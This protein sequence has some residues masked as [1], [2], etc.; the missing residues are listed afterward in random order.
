MRPARQILEDWGRL[1]ATLAVAVVLLMGP[2]TAV[3]SPSEAFVAATGPQGPG[4]YADAIEQARVVVLQEMAKQRIPGMSAA[5]AVNGEII[6]SE[7]FGYA[8]LENRVPAWPTTLYR[9]GSVSKPLT[10]A[11]VARLYEQGHLELDAPVQRYVPS[12]PDKRYA[13]STRQV[14][15]HLAGIRAYREDEFIAAGQRHYDDVVDALVIF[16][17]DP[18]LFPPGKQYSY[19]SFGWNLISAV[20]RGAADK[21]FLTVMQEEVFDPL[22]MRHT[23]A[24]DPRRIVPHRTRFYTLLDDQVINAPFVDNSYKWAGGGFISS[25]EDLVRFGS[26]HLQEGYLRPETLEL[27]FTS[28]HTNAGEETGYGIGWSLGLLGEL[29]PDEVK[30][31]HRSFNQLRDYRYMGHGGGAVGGRAHLL[32][33]PDAKLVVAILI[34]FEQLE[35]GQTAAAIAVPFIQAQQGAENP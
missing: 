9:I 25:V 7:G 28:Q 13:L 20:V 21:D 32:L 31:D 24:D 4:Y 26:A 15:G 30:P 34:N 10:A 6:W 27:L 16:Q 19:T 12:F 17:N 23:Y 8:D 2:A 29:T 33:V 5:V 22:E 35:S 11:A 18:L 1:T 14:A 3:V